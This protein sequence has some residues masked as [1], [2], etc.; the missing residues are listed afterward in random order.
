MQTVAVV[1]QVVAQIVG[2]AT[3]TWGTRAARHVG[4]GHDAVTGPQ[5]HAFTVGNGA[6][7]LHD[8]PHVL[9]PADQRVG[10]VTFVRSP[11]VL[12]RLAAE[13][14]FIGAADAR[15]HHPH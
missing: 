2:I 6:A 8:Y 15:V 11:G 13:G 4:R 3:P 9:V 10:D 12:F 14:V 5:R 7:G 1:L